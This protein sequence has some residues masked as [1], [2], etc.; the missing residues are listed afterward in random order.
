MVISLPKM[1]RTHRVYMVLANSR[2][3]ICHPSAAMVTPFLIV[4]EIAATF[5]QNF[6]C[7]RYHS[8]PHITVLPSHVDV[9]TQVCACL[10]FY[11]CTLTCVR[12]VRT[13]YCLSTR[14]C[15]YRCVCLCVCMSVCMCVRLCVY[16]TYVQGTLIHAIVC[17][18]VC[19]CL[20]V[21]VR[22]RVYVMYIQGTTYPRDCVRTGMSVCLNVCV[23]ACMCT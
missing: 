12:N 5:I 19:V 2:C 10:C 7:R 15:A 4:P 16:V 23:C 11:V 14:L 13:R 9:R 1:P 21:Y 6:I 20:Y 22:L 8:H 3:A 18:K 17:I